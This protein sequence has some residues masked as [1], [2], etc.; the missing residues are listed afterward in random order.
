MAGNHARSYFEMAPASIIV[1]L[2]EVARRRLQHLLLQADGNG[3]YDFPDVVDGHP[4]TSRLRTTPARS[5]TS[6]AKSSS[7]DA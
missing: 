5:S 1:R 4:R 7:D 2:T 6:A 3:E